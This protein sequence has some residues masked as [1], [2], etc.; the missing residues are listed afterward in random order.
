MEGRSFERADA[1]EGDGA[2]EWGE[3]QPS[4][5]W[6]RRSRRERGI[7]FPDAVIAEA[8]RR[9]EGRC[10]CGVLGHRHLAGCR[11]LLLRA[12]RDRET[13]MGWVADAVN[14]RGRAVLDNCRILCRD[15]HRAMSM[16]HGV[17]GGKEEIREARIIGG[18][19]EI[20]EARI[21]RSAEARRRKAA[22][23]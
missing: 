2:D 18:E 22:G 5:R 12:S 19:E 11:K 4:A 23:P 17:Q 21:I 15:C 1:R 8:W 16:P 7:H 9:A 13:P 3:D 20:P 10:E 6:S 14:Q